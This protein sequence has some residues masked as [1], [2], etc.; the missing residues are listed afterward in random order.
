MAISVTPWVVST[1]VNAGDDALVIESP[2]MANLVGLTGTA[3]PAGNES[4]LA[5]GE[6]AAAAAFLFDPAARTPLSPHATSAASKP[7]DAPARNSVR[8]LIGMLTSLVDQ[9]TD[10]ASTTPR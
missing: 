6:P 5:V 10:P 9:G 4:L 2:T 8:R 1:F 7:P 3:E